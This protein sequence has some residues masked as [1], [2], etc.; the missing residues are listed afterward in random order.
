MERKGQQGIRLRDE[1]RAR[2]K[3]TQTGPM[4]VEIAG[5]ELGFSRQLQITLPESIGSPLFK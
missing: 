2:F 1:C 4:G 5:K 3:W